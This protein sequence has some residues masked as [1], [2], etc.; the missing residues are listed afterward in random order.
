MHPNSVQYYRSRKLNC[1]PH[2]QGLS[3]GEF[4]VQQNIQQRLMDPYFHTLALNCKYSD[5]K[6]FLQLGSFGIELWKVPQLNHNPQKKQPIPLSCN[7][8]CFL[9]KCTH[10]IASLVSSSTKLVCYFAHGC[11]NFKT[12]KS[13]LVNHLIYHKSNQKSRHIICLVLHCKH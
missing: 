10:T 12:L 3:C 11:T 7:D 5:V 2:L 8:I 9:Q 1:I 13:P 4:K 6:S